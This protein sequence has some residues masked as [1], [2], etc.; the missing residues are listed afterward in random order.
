MTDAAIADKVFELL[1]KRRPE[2][3]VCPSE[4]ARALLPPDDAQSWRAAMPAVRRVAARLAA[5]GRLRVTQRGVPVAHA[6]NA[7]GPIRLGR[8]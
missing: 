2:A 6:E 4:V 3:T 1:E 7:G 8:A 5:A